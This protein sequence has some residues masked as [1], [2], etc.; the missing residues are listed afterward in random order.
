[1]I[2]GAQALRCHDTTAAIDILAGALRYEAGGDVSFYPAYLRGLAHLA[3]KDGR[4]AAQEFQKITDHSGVMVYEV[5]GP[6]AELGMARALT[7][8]GDL[9]KAKTAYQNFLAIWRDADA[10]IPILKEARSEY[11]RL[12]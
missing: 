9:A 8:S 11:A 7:L 4:A 6:L 2:L 1:L 5:I 12:P 3:A 10:D